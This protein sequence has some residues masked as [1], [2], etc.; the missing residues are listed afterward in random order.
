MDNWSQIIARCDAE[1]FFATEQWRPWEIELMRMEREVQIN[2]L[3]AFIQNK[4]VR[5][6]DA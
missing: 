3:G 1:N 2:R 4:P 5:A 6:L